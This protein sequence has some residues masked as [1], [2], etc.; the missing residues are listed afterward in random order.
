ML[1][2]DLERFH[3][4]ATPAATVLCRIR[5][6]GN[7]CVHPDLEDFQ[8]ILEPCRFAIMAQIRAIAADLRGDR[9]AGFWMD[10][11]FAR[12]RKQF[13][14][15]FEPEIFRRDILGNR[16]ALGFLALALFDIGSETAHFFGDFFIT[17][18]IDAQFL[19]TFIL[20]TI[21]ATALR[22]ASGK[23]AFRIVGA[24]NKGTKAAT[25]QGQLAFAA[26]R[27]KPWIA[28]VFLFGKEIVAKENIQLCRDF[29][30][31]FFHDFRGFRFEVMPECFQNGLPLCTTATDFI[32]FV[33]EACCIIIGDIAIEE[34]LEKSGQQAPTFLCEE[35][36]FLD[37]HIGAVFQCLDD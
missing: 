2:H 29:R 18:G 20:V 32:E 15:P 19:R 8:C 6:F 13:H 16:R 14:R 3:L 25:A 22:K 34:T 36:V 31:Q 27:T 26:P 37:P 10:A 17:I 21:G 23:F 28:A 4:A 11:D 9:L 1:A 33:F 24:C 7:G 35:P 12:Q 5:Q 30:R